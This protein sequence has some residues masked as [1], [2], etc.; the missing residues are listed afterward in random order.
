MALATPGL[1]MMYLGTIV[2]VAILSLTGA[3]G[4]DKKESAGLRVASINLAK[5]VNEYKFTQDAERQLRNRQSELVSEM[6]SWDQHKLLSEADQ[7]ALGQIAI[8]DNDKVALTP[9]ETA[10]KTKIE[11]TSKRLFDEYLALQTQQG[12][13]PAQTDRLKELSRLEADT[14]KRI[15]ERQTAGQEELQKLNQDLHGK[16]DEAIKAAL[17]EVAKAKAFNVVFSADYAVYCENDI[18]EDVVKKLNK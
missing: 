6:N 8:K 14:N 17:A 7:R 18:T 3:R 15:K 10:S 13:T 12:A 11:E 5:T 16:I 1:R 4:Q 9:Q 2:T